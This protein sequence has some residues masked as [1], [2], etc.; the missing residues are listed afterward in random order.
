ML[1][2]EGGGV[3]GEFEVRRTGWTEG[4]EDDKGADG[5]C[6][7][8]TRR[9]RT[10]ANEGK[11]REEKRSGRGLMLQIGGEGGGRTGEGGA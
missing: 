1:A 11:E 3:Q 9:S 6:V 2:G 4:T 8:N 5:V 10:E 7:T